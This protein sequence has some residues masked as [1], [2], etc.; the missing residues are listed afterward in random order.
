[1]ST[2]DRP[3]FPLANQR[4]DKVD[5]EA[6]SDLVG[7][8]IMRTVGALLGP[9]GGL[10]SDVTTTYD[11]T[12]GTLTI[13][14][15]RLGYA[16][17]AD[18]S[19]TNYDGG[20]VRWDPAYSVS[21]GVVNVATLGT[22]AGASGYIFF[23]KS[24][25]ETDEENRAYYDALA[26][27]KKVGVANTRARETALF[28]VGSSYTSF[29]TSDGY[30]PFLYLVWNTTGG[31]PTVYR[32]S[33]FDSFGPVG[34]Q[35]LNVQLLRKTSALFGY[36]IPWSEGHVGLARVVREIVGGLQHAYDKD[37]TLSSDGSIATNVSDLAYRWAG[38][39]LSRGIKQ[40]DEDLTSA[41]SAI[42]SLQ[43]DI[44]TVQ[45]DL[46]PAKRRSRSAV[47][48]QGCVDWDAGAGQFNLNYAGTADNNLVVTISTILVASVPYASR[49]NLKFYAPGWTVTAVHVTPA[50]N[51]YPIGSSVITWR[52]TA[53]AT[54][55][56]LPFVATPGMLG[57]AEL[58]VDVA[59][60]SALVDYN[61]I[62]T[63]F[64]SL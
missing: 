1:M 44:T 50:D 32:I 6:I 40:L 16:G 59:T 23:K 26:Q 14:A 9:C 20:I 2:G 35:L 22:T 11:G 29:N 13:G 33:A 46:A 48:V 18:G 25:L 52:G 4:L 37:F 64:Y 51:T 21:G 5:V 43:N 30:F 38:Y 10:L 42:T 12:G 58:N 45:T 8:N 24:E 63:G 7:E 49:I 19:S 61:F 31:S 17:L 56:S 3:I 55:S 47:L 62:I 54:S 27:E 53:T 39:G 34:S 28:A 41:E 60:E 57:Y 36:G 15:C